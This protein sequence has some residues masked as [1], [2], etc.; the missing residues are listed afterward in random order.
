VIIGYLDDFD[1]ENGEI[2]SIVF[3]EKAHLEE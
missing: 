2:F 1:A 3:F